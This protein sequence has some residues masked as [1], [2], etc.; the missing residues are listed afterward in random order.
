MLSG[1][2]HFF[3]FGIP[4]AESESEETIGVP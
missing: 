1:P 2:F 3:E 4:D